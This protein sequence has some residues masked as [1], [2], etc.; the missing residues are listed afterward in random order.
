M[1]FVGLITYRFGKVY[2]QD[3]G[4]CGRGA[5]KGR[6]EHSLLHVLLLC[7]SVLARHTL[8]P[9]SSPSEVRLTSVCSTPVAESTVALQVDEEILFGKINLCLTLGIHHII[10]CHA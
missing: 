5:M 10:S 1:L 2:L 7:S 8:L 4:S 3:C 6:V 9:E